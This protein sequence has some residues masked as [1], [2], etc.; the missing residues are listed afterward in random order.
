M[1]AHQVEITPISSSRTVSST[2]AYSFTLTAETIKN[3]GVQNRIYPYSKITNITNQVTWNCDR[4]FNTDGNYHF[5]IGG[6][7]VADT[8]KAHKTDIT[9]THSGFQ[10]YFQSQT[11]NAGIPTGTLEIN[12]TSDTISADFTVK[13]WKITFD[14]ELPVFVVSLSAGTG[15]TV[16]GAGTYEVGTN[17]TITATPANGYKFVKWNDGNTNASRTVTVA[18]GSQ[19]AFSTPLSYTAIFEKEKVPCTVTYNGNGATGGSVASQSGNVGESLTLAKNGFE[20]IYKVSFNRND[21]VG[22]L[23]YKESKA[24]F[25]GWYTAASGGTKVGDGGASYT[26]TGNTTLYAHWSAMPA[27]TLDTPERDGYTFLG[28]YTA[29]EGGAKVGDGGTSYTPSENMSLYAH[30]EKINVP[31]EITSAAITYGGAQV[32]KNNKVPSGEGYLI[33]VGIK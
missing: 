9:N 27:V 31:P 2:K 19:T 20:K 17:A 6:T 4:A 14:Y 7:Q 11:A 21:E 26:P 15:G 23:G 24:T 3:S 33:A 10:G 28:W 8:C 22:Y 12:F 1:A 5:K 25:Q 29:A 18:N 16:S 30:W 32:S 13:L